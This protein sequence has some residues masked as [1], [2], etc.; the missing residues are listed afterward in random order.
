MRDL[1]LP[2]AL[3]S[4]RN[5]REA[6]QQLSGFL[7]RNGYHYHRHPW[8]LLHRRWMADLKFDQPLHYIVLQDCI[9]AVEASEQH[10]ATVWK[11][12]SS[13]LCRVVSGA[14]GKLAGIA[15]IALVSAATLVAELG[16]I[17]RFGNPRQLAAIGLVPSEHSS[18]RSRRQGRITKAG[19]AA[20]RH[21][22]VRRPGA[23]GS[24]P[25]SAGTALATGASAK[26]DP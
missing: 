26:A 17:A 4:V 8:T 10:G 25:A 14:A 1:A 22:L 15:R 5:V 23:I 20:A 24:P 13:R 11:L 2:C 21:M 9:A 3:A 12:A 7:L 19:N 16:D 18:G 6:R